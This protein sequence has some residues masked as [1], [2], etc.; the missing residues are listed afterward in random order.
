MLGLKIDFLIQHVMS[1]SM[2]IRHFNYKNGGGTPT[3]VF[4]SL[5]FYNGKIGIIYTSLMFENSSH[6]VFMHFGLRNAK[7]NNT[8]S[9]YVN[10]KC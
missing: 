10:Y 4:C 1:M 5:M 6:L 7:L 2:T 8:T 3:H 9:T